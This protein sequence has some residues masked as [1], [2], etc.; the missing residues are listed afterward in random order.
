MI[1]VKGHRIIETF[2]G[3]ELFSEA[4]EELSKKPVGTYGIAYETK[5]EVYEK[6]VVNPFGIAFKTNTNTELYAKKGGMVIAGRCATSCDSPEMQAVRK[7]GGEVLQYLIPSEVPDNGGACDRDRE[8]YSGFGAKVPLWPFAVRRKWPDSK[9][10]D[11]RPGSPWILYTI[12]YIRE[13]I[14]SNK[15]DG[16]FL[17]TVGAMT[18]AKLA[19]WSS[20]SLAEKDAYT[21]GNIDLVKRIDALKKELKREDFIVVTNSTWQRQDN[22]KKGFEGEKYVNGVCLEHHASTSEW[23]QNYANKPFNGENRRVLIIAN[24]QEEAVNWSKVPGVTHVSGQTTPEY[25]NP[26]PPPIPFIT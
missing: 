24:S 23:H 25:V 5:V 4:V 17:D 20:W 2:N 22:D 3:H 12:K 1:K 6:E 21:L 26:L 8:Y 10:T 13:L 15:C 16:L 11:M 18:W 7:G 9:M 19:N 14:L